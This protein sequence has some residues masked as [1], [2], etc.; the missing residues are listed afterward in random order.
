MT[1]ARICPP[2]GSL[3]LFVTFCHE[4]LRPARAS[5]HVLLALLVPGICTYSSLGFG[6]LGVMITHSSARYKVSECGHHSR[7]MVAKGRFKEMFW[8]CEDAEQ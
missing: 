1:Q 3:R 4:Q 8:N 2:P 6:K 5:M 7:Y